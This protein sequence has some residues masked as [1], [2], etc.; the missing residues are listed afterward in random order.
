M[1]L[2]CANLNSDARILGKKILHVKEIR[3]DRSILYLGR[4]LHFDLGKQIG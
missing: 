1:A 4:I 2:D 3:N